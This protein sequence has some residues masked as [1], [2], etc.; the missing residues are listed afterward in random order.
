M[1]YRLCAWVPEN[2]A[3]SHLAS[4][5]EF[6]IGTLGLDAEAREL[7]EAYIAERMIT[8]NV[9]AGARDRGA[10]RGV[11]M[12]KTGKEPDSVAMMRS[13]RDKISAEIEGMTLE[14]ELVWL[15]SRELR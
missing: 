6:H 7:A 13:V 15:A 1:R 11:A 9:R 8:V 14:E 10:A 2:A 4:V 3:H 12:S 5:P